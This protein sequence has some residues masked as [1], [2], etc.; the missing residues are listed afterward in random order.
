MSTNLISR[1]K[2]LI[3]LAATLTAFAAAVLPQARAQ[4]PTKKQRKQA[5][6][7]YDA[8]EKSFRARNYR[9]AVDQYQQSLAL[10]PSDP[11]THA[12]KGE[13]HY[14][15]KEYDQSL[16]ELNQAL[17]QKYPKPLEIYKLR[18]F[19]LY[20]KGD[21]DAALTDVHEV[22]KAEPNN[23]LFILKEADINS[24]KGNDREALGAYQKAVAQSPKNADLY[25]KIASIQHKMGET[26]AQIASA[27][28]AIKRNTQFLG[29][30][31]YIA[32]DGYFKK[33]QYEQ[34]EQAYSRAI[35]RWKAANTIKP[36]L[37][38][39]Y[40]NLGDIYRRMNRF[41]DAIRVTRQ[42]ILDYPTDG[43]LWTDV[44]WYYSLADRNAD[45]VEAAKAAITFAP[46]ESLP[47]TNLCRAYNDT[48]QYQLAVNSCNQA[49]KIRPDDG[50]THFY[51]G[52]AYDLLANAAEDAGKTAEANRLKREATG[53]YDK[54]V[55]G[56]IKFT[57]ENPDYSDGFYLLG[58]AY[59]ADDQAAN[60]ISSYLKCLELSP[61]FGKARYNL[62]IIYALN[63]NKPAAMEQYNSLL[64]LDQA[65]AAKLKTEIDKL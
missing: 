26:D 14:F 42:G 43:G 52:R 19:V 57:K 58:N 65:L 46:K 29:D 2:S 9:N 18:A 28:E 15:L 25:Y 50:E 31:F 39:S 24:A 44:S 27:E 10:V 7:L 38:E 23:S 36:E 4:E 51:L 55:S 17:S 6:E 35:D 49:L 34:A 40:R 54:A 22:L 37:Y 16:S 41:S 1:T 64:A 21:F 5:R 8:G 11:V 30:A 33:K 62:G 53:S 47:Y 12:R 3:F 56:L 45:A 63:K 13:A 59:F 32:A 20:E 48:R 61:R 60:A